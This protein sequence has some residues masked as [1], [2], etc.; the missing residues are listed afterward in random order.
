[1]AHLARAEGGEDLCSLHWPVAL[2]ASSQNL[3]KGLSVI[4]L[5]CGCWVFSCPGCLESVTAQLARSTLL[6]PC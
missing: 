6:H 5:Y 4:F 1:M 3:M 2:A